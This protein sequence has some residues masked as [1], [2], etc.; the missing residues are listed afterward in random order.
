MSA[1]RSIP[2]HS[3]ACLAM[4]DNTS[5]MKYFIRMFCVISVIQKTHVRI[6]SQSLS[7]FTLQTFSVVMPIRV[8]YETRLS[9]LKSELVFRLSCQQELVMIPFSLVPNFCE[10]IRAFFGLNKNGSFEESCV[11]I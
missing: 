9:A 1:F 4:F 3:I 7:T 2:S 6:F 5:S 10:T 11:Y 8:H